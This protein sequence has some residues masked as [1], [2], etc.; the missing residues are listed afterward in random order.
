[1]KP[2]IALLFL[3]FN[4]FSG[5]AQTVK[6]KPDD[7]QKRIGEMKTYAIQNNYNREICL[8]ADM[9]IHSG[10]HRFFIVDLQRDSLIRKGKV[11]HGCGANSWQSRRTKEK[12][13]FSNRP[14]SHCTSLGK[15][16]IG[17]RG[18][19]QFGIHVKYLLHGLDST[20][21]NALHRQIVLHSW[22]LVTNKETP[23]GTP[24]GWGC[25]AVSNDLMRLLDRELQKQKTGKPVLLYIYN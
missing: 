5:H 14:E 4:L 20:N 12:P 15:Y 11:S 22:E 6:T 10:Y 17:A 3:L 24:E 18:Y 23:F 2:E 16:S 8:L 25:P 21:S 1:M 13:R 7:L 19:S 9:S